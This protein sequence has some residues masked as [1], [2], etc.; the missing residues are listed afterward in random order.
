M[1]DQIDNLNEAPPSK[2]QRLLGSEGKSL[3][4]RIR[5]GTDAIKTLET[6]NPVVK[7]TAVKAK[8]ENR[9]STIGVNQWLVS[10]LKSMAIESPTAIQEACIPKILD[11]RDCIGGSRT[12]SGKT[13]AFAIPILQK[14]VDDPRGIYAVILTVTR[15]LALQIYEQFMSIS[16]TQSLRL[17][18]VVGG[19]EMWKQ[20]TELSQRPHIVIATPGR[21]AEHIRTGDEDTIRGLRKVEVL[22]LD[23]ADRLLSPGA[24]SMLPDLS[25]CV[26]V[27]P[28][29]ENRQTLMFTATMTP[30]VRMSIK[31]MPRPGGKAE[32]FVCETSTEILAIPPKLNQM[33]LLV[34]ATQRESYLHVLLKTP[35]N[36]AHSVII[37]CNRTSTAEL[38]H[39]TLHLLE[40]NV[41]SLHS[42]LSQKLRSQ[43]LAKFRAGEARILIA[44][45][46]ASRGL[47]I[48][49]VGLVVNY[50]IPRDPND[51]IH[52]VGRTARVDSPGDAITF[53]GQQKDIPRILAIEARVGRKMAE[54][55][56]EKVNI[57]T[58]VVRDAIRKVNRKKVEAS[59]DIEDN[60]DI[61]GRRRRGMRKITGQ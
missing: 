37:F 38:L 6:T 5:S 32:I 41:T 29:S 47:D 10:S 3:V 22:V 35:R 19:S 49:I 40:H 28:L 50:D 16:A 54:Y 53:A 13:M 12:G 43:N 8:G 44:T 61:T 20:A 60:R 58:R 24:G 36:E 11:G 57:D 34:P 18:L 39:H 46:V 30:E 2:R 59:L 9:F 55:E 1:E 48:P 27:L 52:R 42:K 33:Y 23:E 21:L 45:D 4:S 7:D 17:S 51:Y 25:E 26:S 15:E 14:L 31:P 56:E